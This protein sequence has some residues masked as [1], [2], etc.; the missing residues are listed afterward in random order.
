MKSDCWDSRWKKTKY[1][2]TVRTLKLWIFFKLSLFSWIK[3]LKDKNI[4]F[5]TIVLKGLCSVLQKFFSLWNKTFCRRR[6]S[7]SYPLISI[8]N[9]S[10]LPV[11]ISRKLKYKSLERKW[12]SQKRIPLHSW[13]REE[14]NILITEL[15]WGFLPPS[16]SLRG[17]KK[18]TPNQSQDIK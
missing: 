1:T 4:L 14:D 17:I 10:S 11:F 12:H 3:F 8:P 13:S 6:E 2:G 15:Q 9:S 7:C 5:I 18:Y 16:E